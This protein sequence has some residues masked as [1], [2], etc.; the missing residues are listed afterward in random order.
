MIIFNYSGGNLYIALVF[1][2]VIAI[3]L[4][5]GMPTTAAYAICASVLA[6]ALIQ[7][8]VP[9]IAAHLFIFYFGLLSCLTPPV[10]VPP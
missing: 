8:N 5:M 4:G 2:M 10:A 3:V 7:L 9:D 1:T 6:P